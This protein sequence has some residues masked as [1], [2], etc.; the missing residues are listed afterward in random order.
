MQ[1]TAIPSGFLA[2][3]LRPEPVQAPPVADRTLH[4]PSNGRRWLDKLD[5]LAFS[6]YLIAFFMGVVA[7]V[8]WQCYLQST[9][10]AVPFVATPP[11]QQINAILLDTV[12][13][14]IDRLAASQE[15]MTR[16][17]N[18]LQAG[19]FVLYRHAEPS[20]RSNSAPATT[21]A[22]TMPPS[23]GA[24]EADAR[25]DWRRQPCCQWPGSGVW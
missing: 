17:I 4:W 7:T 8:A 21:P 1:M 24:A 2:A 22:S 10:Q 13:R 25:A 14:S 18:K 20:P 15:Q 9:G 6:R 3:S 16:E 23:H 11:E 12:R 19:Q 5:P